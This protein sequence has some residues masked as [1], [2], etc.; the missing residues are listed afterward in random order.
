[1]KNFLV[2]TKDRIVKKITKFF[3]QNR[4]NRFTALHSLLHIVICAN[5]TSHLS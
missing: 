4:Y 5:G 2:S 3:I 1:M